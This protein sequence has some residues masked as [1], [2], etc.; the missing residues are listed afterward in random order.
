MQ[1]GVRESYTQSPSFKTTYYIHLFRFRNSSVIRCVTSMVPNSR[2]YSSFVVV[3]VDKQLIADP[4]VMF[5][6]RDNP[7]L[8]SVY[9]NTAIQS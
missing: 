6:Y 4:S 7:E 9:P 5:Q 8:S 1:C 2:N 3:H